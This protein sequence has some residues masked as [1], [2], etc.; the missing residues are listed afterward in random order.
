MNMIDNIQILIVDD[1]E[2]NLRTLVDLI[3]ETNPYYEVYQALNANLALKIAEK[4]LPNLIIS[5]WEMPNM[6]GIE[7]LKELKK[8]EKTKDIPVIICSGVMISSENLRTALEAGAADFI[9]KPL[10]KIELMARMHSMLK[11]SESYKEI[12]RLNET[13]DYIFSVIG[14]DL[15]GP[16]KNI[17]MLIDLLIK[18]PSAL[19]IKNMEQLL[20]AAS[21][22]SEAT[23]NL[24]EN[25]LTWARN[26]QGKIHYSP[27]YYNVE[28]I[29]EESLELLQMSIRKKSINLSLSL[30]EELKIYVDKNQFSTIIRNLVSNA[31]KFTPQNGNVNIFAYYPKK[32]EQFVEITVKDSGVGISPENID[33]I[34][35]FK[36]QIST[37]G[38]DKEKGLGLGLKLTMEFI[39][40]NGGKLKINSEINKG[41]SFAFTLP[42]K[43]NV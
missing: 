29:I 32:E 4:H 17:K 33:K 2:F 9:R 20:Y 34:F 1:E 26:Q 18:S 8:N 38:T 43:R 35:N 24:L 25:L 13:K 10:D 40:K 11:L 6:N 37:Y 36:E 23:Y 28:K 41:S 14:H 12:K 31:L 16:I 30:P 15:R 7:M 27:D 22:S 3:E 5:D 42:I 19:S 39:E 21:R